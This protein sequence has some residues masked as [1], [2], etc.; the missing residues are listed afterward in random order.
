MFKTS[1]IFW[2]YPELHN[3]PYSSLL[4]DLQEKEKY[5]TKS[6]LIVEMLQ[7]DKFLTIK[8]TTSKEIGRAEHA[9]I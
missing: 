6:D 1:L 4:K 9:E 2:T 3:P 8:S 5:V 7:E